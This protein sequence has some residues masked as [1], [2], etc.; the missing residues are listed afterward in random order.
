ME[1]VPCPTVG[2]FE[3]IAFYNLENDSFKMSF[4]VFDPQGLRISE[5]EIHNDF[6]AIRE[7]LLRP[8]ALLSL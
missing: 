5:K 7:Y 4:N 3:I 1:V 8:L 2:K 6:S